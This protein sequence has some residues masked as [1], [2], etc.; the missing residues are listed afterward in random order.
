MA[1]HS[2]ASAAKLTFEVNH[3]VR[4]SPPDRTL[5]GFT[6]KQR[7]TGGWYHYAY[8]KHPPASNDSPSSPRGTPP[9]GA[10]LFSLVNVREIN[11]RHDA[12]YPLRIVQRDGTACPHCTNK[13][14]ALW[15][16]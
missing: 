7:L 5:W 14:P 11:S 12:A 16:S 3:S 6:I 1:G 13:F 10:F 8:R 15:Q 9:T 4:A 2:V